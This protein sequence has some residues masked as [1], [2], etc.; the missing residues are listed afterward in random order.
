MRL[1]E[2]LTEQDVKKFYHGSMIKLPVGAILTPRDNY[3]DN[4]SEADFF[5]ALEMHRPPNMLSHT[6]AVFMCSKPNDI[7]LVGGGTNWLFTVAP[8]GPIQKH[9]VNWGSEIAMLHEAGHKMNSPEIIKAA[10]NYWS[11]KPHFSEN[12]WEFLTPKA[13]ILKVEKF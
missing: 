12:V 8:L 9:D 13:E 6:K 4:W 5:H 10:K 3:A 1:H 11:G 2:F 7:D